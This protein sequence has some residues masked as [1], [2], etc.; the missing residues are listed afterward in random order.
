M[1][2]MNRPN[3]QQQQGQMMPQ[4]AQQWR[5]Q[6]TGQMMPPM[7]SGQTVMPSPR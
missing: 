5:P 2:G 3:G 6:T 7:Q 4:T 1:F